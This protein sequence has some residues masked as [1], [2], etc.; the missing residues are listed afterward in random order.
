MSAPHNG[1]R[2]VF[3]P[4]GVIKM[5]EVLL[6]LVQPEWEDCGG[7]EGELR[8]LL[9]AACAAW[10]V[11][12]LKEA[13]RTAFLERLVLKVPIEFR[14]DLKQVIEEFI[15]RKDQMFPHIRRPILSFEL[16]GLP[17]GKAHLNVL[18]GLDQP[19]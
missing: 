2:L 18:S 9:T 10:N 12:L 14:Q 17:S 4:P 5:S 13:E 7:D 11:A 19:D 15:I 1:M 16:T 6:D 8:K 3:D